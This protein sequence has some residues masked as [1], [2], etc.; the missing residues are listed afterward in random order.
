MIQI[1]QRKFQKKK[2]ELNKIKEEL[3]E[4][5]KA[6]SLN[7]ATLTAPSQPVISL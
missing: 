2:E 3:N 4:T 6:I 1:I 7:A 5:K